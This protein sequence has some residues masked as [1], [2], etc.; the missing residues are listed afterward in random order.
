MLA[1]IG[2][3]LLVFGLWGV[4]VHAGYD[5]AAALRMRQQAAQVQAVA[6]ARDMQRMADV[7]QLRACQT[8]VLLDYEYQQ[9][10]TMVAR[11]ALKHAGMAR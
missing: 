7:R 11:S 8:R 2:L 6:R 10:A 9:T 3:T 4:A 1:R 5:Y